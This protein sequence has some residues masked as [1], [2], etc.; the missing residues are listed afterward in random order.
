LLVLY[1]T[2]VYN[3]VVG[4]WHSEQ[5]KILLNYVPLVQCKNGI[6]RSFI[7]KK[8]FIELEQWKWPKQSLSQSH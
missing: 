5:T 6:N 3:I 7:Y 2:P 8:N 1:S 4:S